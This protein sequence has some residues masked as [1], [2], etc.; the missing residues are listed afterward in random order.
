MSIVIRN[1]SGSGAFEV[2]GTT[3]IDCLRR[4]GQ[5]IADNKPL[6]DTTSTFLRCGGPLVQYSMKFAHG[7]Q[8]ILSLS[9]GNLWIKL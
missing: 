4:G 7:K 6:V 8:V 1:N 2:S 9:S 3:L 5:I